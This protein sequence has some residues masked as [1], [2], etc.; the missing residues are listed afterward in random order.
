M[1]RA[2]PF[3]LAV[4]ALAL[5]A[6]ACTENIH[7]TTPLGI[8]APRLRPRADET[9]AGCM[10]SADT[11]PGTGCEVTV[12]VSPA[13]PFLRQSSLPPEQ[14][15]PITLVF[16]KPV[17]NVHVSGSGA[18]SCNHF[19]GALVGYDSAGTELARQ[20]LALIDPEDCAEDGVTFGAQATLPSP[21]AYA[22]V[23]IEPMSPFQ[24]PVFD[25]VGNSTAEYTVTFGAAAPDSG[26]ITLTPA[27]RGDLRPSVH[28]TTN[29]LCTSLT[30]VPQRRGYTVALTRGSGASA[31]PWPGQAVSLTLT[32]VDE[33][34]GHV[35][36]G[37]ERPLGSFEPG[38]T[39]HTTQTTVTTDAQGRARFTF[40]APE[41]G[42]K[43]VIAAHTAGA[44]DTTDT[45]TVAVGGLVRLGAGTS[46]TLF[47]E[48]AQHP[49]SHYATTT[50]RNALVALADSFHTRFG[51]QLFIN[52]ESLALGGRFD[53]LG[54][55]VDTHHC[56]HR[57]GQGAD[58]RTRDLTTAQQNYV[59]LTWAALS[60]T[61]GYLNEGSPVHYHLKTSN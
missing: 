50:M 18:I 26:K 32:A 53:V 47:G 61:N 46:Y 2:W 43:Y 49:D 20:D 57:Y 58:L 56:D 16:S 55:W 31:A 14:T 38:Q 54:N 3:R 5:A 1:H 34:G 29:P 48:L 22:K 51:L 15:G 19:V 52:D 11:G 59:R 24:F 25:L 33:S 39:A 10:I 44:R 37:G 23:V 4:P 7:Q 27:Q 9:A 28:S 60:G 8:D 17:T 42:G 36:H 41:F 12:Q 30:Y 35:A 6:S 40:E 13:S 21:Q 45:V